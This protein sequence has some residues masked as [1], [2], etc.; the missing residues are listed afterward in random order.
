VPCPDIVIKR[1]LEIASASSSD[2]H[3]DLGC[4][5]GR[6]NFAAVASPH[7]VERS[8]GVD[9]DKTVLE[10]A[11]GRLGRRFVPR[12]NGS[13]SSAALDSNDTDGSIGSNNGGEK[14]ELDK[15]EFLQA[16]LIQV[17]QREKER[18]QQ[19]L[20]D[21]MTHSSN[22]NDYNA[23]L[24][25]NET[26][27][28]DNIRLDEIHSKI[29]SSTLITMYFIHS[30]LTQLKP[31]LSSIF[32]GKDKVRIVT[33][34]YEMP[35]WEPSW[36]ERVLDLTVFRYDM[37]GVDCH[38]VEWGLD[39]NVGGDD[40]RGVDGNSQNAVLL[41]NINDDKS[42]YQEDDELSP[43]ILQRRQ[44]EM[45]LLNSN[46]RIH[47]DEELDDIASFRTKRMALHHSTLELPEEWEED[48]DF[49]EE[50][51]D[52]AGDSTSVGGTRLMEKNVKGE[53]R[54]SL[55]AG[56]DIGLDGDEKNKKEKGKP[57]WR[58]PE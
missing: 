50:E 36:A 53:G 28:A 57:V 25:P 32:G 18:Y 5:D 2:R 40:G 11:R 24:T 35:D 1:V 21:D 10:R 54:K 37:K 22:H 49:D 38:P 46:L 34:G 44:K 9:V 16:D 17:I 39:Y 33:V 56:L 31:Y 13:L 8:V 20:R 6:W 27:T 12:W 30:S 23:S 3:V 41:D 26:S 15:L 14:S 45:D 19:T 42:I 29:A 7:F 4:G 58:K 47:H 52:Y 48:W 55:L 43:S 51:E